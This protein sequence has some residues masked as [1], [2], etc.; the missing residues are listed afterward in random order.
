[1]NCK[2]NDVEIPYAEF[3]W[4]RY[5]EGEASPTIERAIL[6]FQLTLLGVQLQ[7]INPSSG[8]VTSEATV[9][10]LIRI[11]LEF[12]QLLQGEVKEEELQAFLKTHPFVLHPAAKV[13]P[14]KKL[15]EDFVTDF[16][17]VAPN[18]QGPTYILVELERA[19]HPVLNQDNALAQPA[20]HAVKQTRDW[21]IWLEEHKAYL[22]AKLPG[23]ETPTYLI[24]IGR[25]HSLN[26]SQKRYLRSYNREWKNTELLTY[27]DVLVRYRSMVE[28][29]KALDHREPDGV[30]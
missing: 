20:N 1:V 28:R 25:G 17:L 7:K 29:L 18:A 6:D 2:F 15:G 16:V 3:A 27:D 8:Q 12:E 13:I 21:D 30:N 10:Q 4:F 14:K 5:G 22:Q 19:T 23:F 24:V 9:D 11:G 26:D